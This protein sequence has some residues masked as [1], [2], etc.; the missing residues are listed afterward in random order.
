M[1]NVMSLWLYINYQKKN[2]FYCHENKL[3]GKKSTRLYF[4]RAVDMIQ[5]KRKHCCNPYKNKNRQWILRDFH[6][7]Y[8]LKYTYT[9][10][11]KW[12]Q[13]EGIPRAFSQ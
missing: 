10:R 3:V 11:F 8:K 2:F 5:Q 6:S 4:Q 7:Q 12:K 1:N 13:F 9:R